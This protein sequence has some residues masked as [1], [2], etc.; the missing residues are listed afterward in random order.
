MAKD[1][2][3][4]DLDREMADLPPALRWREWMRRIEAVL[5]ASAA[6][7]SREDLARVV[8]QG[9]S[10]DLLIGDLVVELTDRP[11]EIARVTDAWMFRTRT[12]YAPAIRAAATV[13]EQGLDLRAPDV[14]VLA[15]IAYHQPITRD[16]LKDMFGKEISRDLIG[17]LHALGLIGTGPRAPRRR[18]PYTFVTTEQFLAVFGLETLRDL[19]DREQLED[20]GLVEITVP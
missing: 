15:A 8:G 14:A 3:E 9:V 19:P 2:S 13:P 5:F 12:A 10:I 18:A 16:G 20:A 4:P 17:R 11:Y 6:P 7:V 1:P